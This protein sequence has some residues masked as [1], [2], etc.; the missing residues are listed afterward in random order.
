[1]LES[2]P[3]PRQSVL[4]FLLDFLAKPSLVLTKPVALDN[5]V[6]HFAPCLLGLEG[7]NSNSKLAESQKCA[8]FLVRAIESRRSAKSA[9]VIV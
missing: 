5:S 7:A 6:I 2:M 3:E 8:R 4:C 9:T 1:M